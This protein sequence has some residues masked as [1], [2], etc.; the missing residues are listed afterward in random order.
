M[1][2]PGLVVWKD[3]VTVPNDAVEFEVMAQQWNWSYR[4]PG[5]DGVLGTTDATFINDDNPF[6]IKMDDAD[7]RDDVLVQ[8]DDLHLSINQPVKVL[9]RSIDVLHD[10]YVP[11]FRAKMDM[12]PGSVTFFWFEPI[13]TGRFDVMCFELCGTNHYLM[14]GAVVVDAPADYQLWL[15]DQLTFADYLADAAPAL[16]DP[17][18]PA[19]RQA[20]AVAAPAPLAP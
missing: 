16:E 12:V 13:R 20:N 6:G 7:G 3:F 19:Q 11:E 15:Q 17:L 4:L 2:A 14:R 1:L 10:F 8:F 5:E 18:A 9:L